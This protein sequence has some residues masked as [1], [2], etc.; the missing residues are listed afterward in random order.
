MEEKKV[1]KEATLVKSQAFKGALGPNEDVKGDH[2]PAG[3]DLYWRLIF[4]FTYY[5]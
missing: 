1:Q 2:G 3:P 4:N 5:F